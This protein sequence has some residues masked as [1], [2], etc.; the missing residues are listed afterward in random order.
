[1][2]AYVVL[3]SPESLESVLALNGRQFKEKSLRVDRAAGT[4]V[5]KKRKIIILYSKIIF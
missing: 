5:R 3:K 2:N 1:M 4:Q